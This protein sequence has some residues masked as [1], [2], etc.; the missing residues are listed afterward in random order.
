[1]LAG[2]LAVTAPADAGS[3]VVISAVRYDSPGADRGGNKS[4]NA[5][6][7]KITNRSRSARSLTGW[8]LRDRTGHTFRFPAFTLRAG[9][10]VLVHSGKGRATA[11]DRYF[12][13]TWYVWNNTGDTAVLKNRAGK[14]VDTCRWS[15]LGAGHR[16]C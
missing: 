8:T 11:K 10:S 3:P 5:E 2:G 13:L 7:V 15:R 16:S 12:G 14:T 9:R 4:V 6:Y 1:M